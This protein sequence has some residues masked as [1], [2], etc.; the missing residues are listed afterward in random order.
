MDGLYDKWITLKEEFKRCK[1][2]YLQ[3]EDRVLDNDCRKA[4]IM[5]IGDIAPSSALK[6]GKIFDEAV[7][8]YI[9]GFLEYIDIKPEEVYITNLVNCNSQNTKTPKDEAIDV[10]IKC[11]RKQFK[12]INPEIVICL[13]RLV[14]QKLIS[15]DF[16]VKSQHGEFINKGDVMFMG[17]FHPSAFSYDASLKTEMLNDF[18]K[19]KEF[20]DVYPPFRNLTV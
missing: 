19:L 12:L 17:T 4:R 14:C 10:C 7:E 11:L 1:G 13:G 18:M 3:S 15:P 9:Y 5:I 2:C 6:K 20:C 16:K 8:K